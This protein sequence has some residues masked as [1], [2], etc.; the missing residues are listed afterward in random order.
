MQVTGE[1][2]K[3]LRRGVNV[4]LQ[5]GANLEELVKMAEKVPKCAVKSLHFYFTWLLFLDKFSIFR[6]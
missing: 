4:I 1:A 2:K 5:S 3:M 6:I